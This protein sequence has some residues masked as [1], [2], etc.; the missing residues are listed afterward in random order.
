LSGSLR[1]KNHHQHTRGNLERRRPLGE[2]TLLARK[3]N[4]PRDLHCDENASESR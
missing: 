2:N 1:Y 3:N 4:K